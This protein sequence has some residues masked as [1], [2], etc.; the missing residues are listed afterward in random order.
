MASNLKKIEYKGWSGGLNLLA[1]KLRVQSNQ[2][3]EALNVRILPDGVLMT[4]PGAAQVTGGVFTF[5]DYYSIANYKGKYCFHFSDK[6]LI[7]G[8]GVT[9]KTY[10]NDNLGQFAFF[11]DTLLH[12][13]GVDVMQSWNLAAATTS[14]VV[15][16]PISRIIL[17]HNDRIFAV[18]AYSSIVNETTVNTAIDFAGGAAW[19]IGKNDG[20]DITGLAS[21]D[22]DLFI[23]K[24][25]SIWR[26]TGYSQAERQ[27]VKFL[28]DIGTLSPYSIKPVTLSGLGKAIVFLSTDN[29]LCA[30][31]LSTFSNIGE[32]IQPM[33]DTISLGSTV[34]DSPQS[35]VNVRAKQ[36]MLSFRTSESALKK[37]CICLHYE[38]PYK[39]E[40]GLR[41]GFTRYVSGIEPA[42]APV[43]FQAITEAENTDVI[44]GSVVGIAS[45]A[46]MAYTFYDDLNYDLMDTVKTP[47]HFGILTRDEDC[48]DHD[49]LK[50]FRRIMIRFASIVHLT[51]QFIQ[52]VELQADTGT[53]SIEIMIPSTASLEYVSEHWV[54]LLD[55]AKHCSLAINCN[56]KN[57]A[58]FPYFKLVGIQIYWKFGPQDN[59]P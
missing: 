3:T 21:M 52:F 4:R 32:V 30:F 19:N 1:D 49:K 5:A 50:Q 43:S 12:G 9:L 51:F 34:K 45:M 48:G 31:N 41:W 18:T 42:N 40:F 36:Y 26:M 2:L 13:N 35:A 16:A 58:S 11:N 46:Y 6:T 10:A 23:F 37:T 15:G 25:N 7:S 24:Q 55:S 54:G 22:G 47:T 44:F 20:G 33:L 39:S 59:R 14:D 8:T 38:S 53:I 27:I 29:K 57:G 28:P 17:K 56:D